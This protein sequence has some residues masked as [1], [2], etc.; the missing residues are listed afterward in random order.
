MFGKE[1]SNR[2][3]HG[4]AGMEAVLAGHQSVVASDIALTP[5]TNVTLCLQGSSKTLSTVKFAFAGGE[6]VKY[7]AP[8]QQCKEDDTPCPRGG[9]RGSV[10]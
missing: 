5:P 2:S 1:F 10:S 6:E 7:W 3:T 9:G 4:L 8:L